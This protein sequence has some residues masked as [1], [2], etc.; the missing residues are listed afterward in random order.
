[1]SQLVNSASLASSLAPV[2]PHVFDSRLLNK[3]SLYVGH[4]LSRGA[5]VTRCVD[6]QCAKQLHS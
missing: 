4:G 5:A 3:E 6:V 1:M 2:E